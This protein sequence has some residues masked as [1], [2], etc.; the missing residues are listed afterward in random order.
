MT[1]HGLVVRPS[2]SEPVGKPARPS[3]VT[4]RLGVR[5]DDLGGSV[6]VD[7]LVELALRRNPRRAQLLVSTVLGKHVP[8]D[9]RL[10][11][12]RAT[13]LAR[14]TA[15]CVD[16]PAL[17]IGYA[18]TATALGHVVASVLGAPYLHST[19]RA[20][21][22]VASMIEF[23]EV[24]SHASA[25]RLLPEHADILTGGDA[26]VLVDDELS[27]GRTAMNTISALRSLH[28]HSH[29]VVAALV[30]VRGESD[31]SE[32]QD[33]ADRLRVRI[34]VV[35]LG[36]ARLRLPA[37]LADDA[38]H[39]AMAY[40]QPQTSFA[41]TA[42]RS[43]GGWP[44]QV[45][46]SARHGFVAAQGN[47]VD[48][49]ARACAATLSTELLGDD[50]LVLGYEEF[51][52][53]PLLV[54]RELTQLLGDGRRVRFSSTTRSPVLTVDESGYSVRSQLTYQAHDGCDPLVPRFAYNVAP[55][56]G[57]RPF[58]DIVLMV[59]EPANTAELHAPRGLIAALAA[60]CSRVHLVVVPAYRP[61]AST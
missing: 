8:A 30:D 3:W 27:T 36:T 22:G 38:A 4:E 34:D 39:I 25:H 13:Q 26:L 5:L 35:S 24:H 42:I 48:E 47:A 11:Y 9:P 1:Q 29:Y 55:H 52:Y 50:I 10:V 49:A 2:G 59:D 41:P 51:M 61:A 54:A 43:V 53:V 7:D 58:T 17:V 60:V 56:G 20:V 14:A 44:A 6:P 31:R 16:E 45:P 23:D 40:P 21:P 57:A 15:Q 33:F 32:L 46:D 37:S 18:E 12:E 19:R 28:L